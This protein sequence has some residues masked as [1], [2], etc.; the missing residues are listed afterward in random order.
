MNHT[1]HN[2]RH[3]S[4]Q[5]KNI[6]SQGQNP[7]HQYRK[8]PRKQTVSCRMQ[9]NEKCHG[10][11]HGSII[12]KIIWKL[13]ESDIHENVPSIN[14]SSTTKSTSGNVQYSGRK[15]LQWNSK[16]KNI[17][18]N[19]HEILLGQRQNTT[20]SFPHILGRGKENLADYVT[21]HHIICHHIT[22]RSSAVYHVSF[23]C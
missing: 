17:Q 5:V 6:V 12:G 23:N 3:E 8:L 11:S 1:Y 13:P 21:K 9:H 19:R 7:I 22:M 15:N 4:E 2:Q 10:I 18:I 14:G 16:T 20:K